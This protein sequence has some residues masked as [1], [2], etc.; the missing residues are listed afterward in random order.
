MAG[1]PR[2]VE[3]VGFDGSELVFVGYGAVAP[4]FGWD[5]YAGVD[6]TGKT[7]VVLVNDPGSPPR[8]RSSSRATP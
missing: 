5:D 2:V 6:V 4:E 1:T 8:T 3:N 7:V